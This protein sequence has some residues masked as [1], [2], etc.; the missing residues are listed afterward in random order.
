MDPPLPS[1]LAD[2]GERPG[3]DGGAALSQ[4]RHGRRHQDGA[5]CRR[6]DGDLAELRAAAVPGDAFQI[7]LHLYRRR[8]RRVHASAAAARSA[9]EPGF[10]RLEGDEDRLGADGPRA[11]GGG[12]GGLQGTG[13]GKLRPDRGGPGHDRLADRRTRRAQGQRRARLARGRGEAGRCRGQGERELWRALGEESRRD[14]RLSQPAGGQPPAHRRRVAAHRRSLQPRRRWLLLLQGPHRRH[15]QQR[16]REHLSPG[17]RG[18]AAD[19]SRYRR[20]LRRARRPCRQGRGAGGGGGEAQGGQHRRAG[21]EG[22]RAEEGPGLCP[23]PPCA[24]PRCPAAEWRRQDR[25][26]RSQGPGP[27]GNRRCTFGGD[28]KR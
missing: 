12:R 18:A 23:S 20:R 10:L 22:F 15:V 21:G 19:P 9:G 1:L 16:R 17:G 13:A 14:P 26:D 7:P 11:A 25:S 8:A 5:L 6:L 4:E 2:A 28:E 24:L 3:A 27:G